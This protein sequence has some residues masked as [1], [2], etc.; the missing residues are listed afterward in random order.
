MHACTAAKKVVVR[1]IHIVPLI[2][3]CVHAYMY[4]YMYMYMYNVHKAVQ[5]HAQIDST[6]RMRWIITEQLYLRTIAVPPWEQG[7]YSIILA[8]SV[9]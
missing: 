2:A 3:T 6:V 5:G 4:M 7:M 8:I 9:M 1:A